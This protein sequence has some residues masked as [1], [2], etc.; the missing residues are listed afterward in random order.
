MFNDYT[1]TTLWPELRV[2]KHVCED[3]IDT[4]N[5]LRIPGW[6]VACFQVF[7]YGALRTSWSRTETEFLKN[8]FFFGVSHYLLHV[9]LICQCIIVI[10]TKCSTEC[11][12]VAGT[13]A[14]YLRGSGFV[15]QP[16]D[17]LT[18]QDFRS[19]TRS[20]QTNAGTAS[21]WSK[22]T[23]ASFHTFSNSSHHPTLNS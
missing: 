4:A 1:V 3:E 13:P 20:S 7:Y 17:W 22:A 12:Q 19:F 5:N 16:G 23:T 9:V 15:S 10:A 21:T 14:S 18:W 6:P 11:N 2:W 8:F